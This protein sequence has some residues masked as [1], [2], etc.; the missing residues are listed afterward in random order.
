MPSRRSDGALV[1]KLVYYGPSL[2]GKTTAVN[3]LYEKEGIAVGE[4]TSVKGG[5]TEIKGD[6]G[7]FGG[8]FDRMTAKIGK[9]NLQV[10]SVAG[11]KSHKDLRKVILQG[12]DGLVFVWDSQRGAWKENI[13]SLNELITIL[14]RELMKIPFVV[15]LNKFDLPGVITKAN[16][17]EILTKAKIKGDIVET[18]AITGTNVRKALDVCVRAV[19]SKYLEQKQAASPQ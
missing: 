18:S 16:V 19:I 13:E 8:F 10:W 4:L 14:Q 7:K 12:A 9:I 17:E 15:M 2:S 1:F 5:D 11:R 3:W 6:L